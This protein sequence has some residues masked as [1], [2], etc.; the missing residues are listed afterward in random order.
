MS[1]KTVAFLVYRGFRMLDLV[2]PMETF[3]IANR[4]GGDYHI[5]TIATVS[6]SVMASNGFP[7]G[8]ARAYRDLALADIDT[9]MVVGGYAVH[10]Q[11]EDAELVAWLAASPSCVR[12]V[13]SVCTGAFLLAKAG[14]LEGRRATTH[15]ASAGR[16]AVDYPNVTVEPDVLY[17]RDGSVW[18][19]AGVTAGM[20][21]ALALIEED[22]G[23]ETALAT[24]REMVV[25]L[26]R[27]GGQSQFSAELLAQERGGD[28]F[29][30]LRTWIFQNLDQRLDVETLADRAGM[31]RR[32]FQRRFSEAFAVPPAKFIERARVEAARRDLED[33]VD[34]VDRIAATR[35]FG[36]PER[37]RRAFHRVLGVSPADYRARF[38]DT[39]TAA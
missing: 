32:G 12:R 20:D 16:L 7:L 8:G 23:R 37:M 30:T 36:D 18:T 38:R 21:L 22:H 14:L 11:L 27:P 24:A 6:G 13:C 28:R 5:K 10:D 17:Q 9:L 3:D 19:S 39:E 26:K 31:S 1:T 29:D 15:W 34:G 2:G 25:F 4:L 35:G 33:G